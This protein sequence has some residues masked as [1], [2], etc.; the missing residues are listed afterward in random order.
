[1]DENDQL[2]TT[3]EVA[4]L[5]GIKESTLR[6]YRYLN[7]GSGPIS[8]TLGRRTVRYRKSDVLRY[9]DEQYAQTA[10]A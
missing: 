8:F 3:K 2:L 1:M 5:T 7:D 4:E 10:S 6:F 9:L